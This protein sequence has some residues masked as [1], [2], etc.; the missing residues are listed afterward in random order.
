MPSVAYVWSP[1]LEAAANE[2]PANK[3]RSSRVHGL[4]RALGLVRLPGSTFEEAREWEPARIVP[5]N[6]KLSTEAELRR[7]HDPRYVGELIFTSSNLTLRLPSEQRRRRR[8]HGPRLGLLVILN[9]IRRVSPET[10]AAARRRGAGVRLPS[11][12][13]FGSVRAPCSGRN[14]HRVRPG[15]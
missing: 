11:I 9:R 1:Q 8:R 5:P 10:E 3:G 14:S 12:F 15:R 2:L 7:Y 13:L 6:P 4:I